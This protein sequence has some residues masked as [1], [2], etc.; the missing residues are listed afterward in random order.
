MMFRVYR[1]PE[2][3][4]TG[5]IQVQSEDFT[6]ECSF[7]SAPI[8]EYHVTAHVSSIEEARKK[9]VDTVYR[10]SRNSKSVRGVGKRRRVLSVVESLVDLNRGRPVTEEAVLQECIL[11]GMDRNTVL[12]FISVLKEQ[13]LVT[14]VSGELLSLAEEG[15]G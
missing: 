4:H 10:E 2:C 3:S 6:S 7:C 11:A 8:Y 13:G 14:L 15:E 9:V 1:C 12:R 5:Y